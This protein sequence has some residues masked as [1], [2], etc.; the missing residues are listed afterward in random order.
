MADERIVIHFDTEGIPQSQRD[1]D[2][3]QNSAIGGFT[4]L[5]SQFELFQKALSGVQTVATG[6]YSALID[7]NERLNAELL[8]SQTNLASSFH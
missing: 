7:S 8:K 2:R 6:L 4:E 1:I 3:L 5:N